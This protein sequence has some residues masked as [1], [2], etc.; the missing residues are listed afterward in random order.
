MTTLNP[1]QASPR[2]SIVIPAYG[3]AHTIGAV[4]DAVLGQTVQPLEIIVVNDRSPDGLDEAVHGYLNRIVYLKNEQNLGLARTCNRGLR[5]A[6]APYVM[7][8]HSD[9]I[10]DRDYVEK[11]LAH[12]EGD[13]SIGAATGQYLFPPPAALGL[14][15][16]LFAL[17]NL[18]PVETQRLS[19]EVETIS[20]IEGKADLFRTEDLR[21]LGYF[22]GNLT[23]TAEDQD[24]SARL[25]RAGF[26]L[27]QDAR[28]RF[29][30]LFTGTSDSL[31]KILR[32]QRTYARGQAYVALRY[33]R[34]IL[35]S[36]TEN[37]NQRAWHRAGQL[38]FVAGLAASGLAAFLFPA[39]RGLPAAWI[40]L[41]ILSYP[42]LPSPFR[43]PDRW[44]ARLLGPVADILYFTGAVEGALKT[45]LF[46]R[47]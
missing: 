18:L 13:P 41:R 36:S 14:S 20:F 21:K 17:L 6:R 31:W 40:L 22:A 32:K 27:I 25:R 42:Q 43:W 19:R 34:E 45:I 15:D 30:V 3:C 26:R 4:L 5:E 11:L 37:R 33:G 24:L 29:S 38:A 39:V 2:V 8:L 10:L 16:R 1:E 12:L 46:G 35:H 44:L 47:A 23:L 28:C 9:C 7:T